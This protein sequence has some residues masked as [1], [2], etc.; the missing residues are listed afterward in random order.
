M[1]GINLQIIM[2]TI[3]LFAVLAI[4]SQLVSAFPEE[5]A[6]F[7]GIGPGFGPSGFGGPSLYNGVPDGG[8]AGPG[9]SNGFT[10]SGF[11]GR[12]GF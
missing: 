9:L 5:Q 10:G 2:R 4:L 12:R 7:Y 1:N 8:F 6:R 11:G 3:A